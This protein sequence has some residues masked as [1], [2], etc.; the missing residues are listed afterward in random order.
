M[1]LLGG[2]AKTLVLGLVIAAIGCLRGLRTEKGPSAVG[3]S[4]TKAVV[5]GIV[6]IVI[7]DMIFGVVYFYLGI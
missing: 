7:A 6:L 2:V 5:A 4:T 3:D 1:D